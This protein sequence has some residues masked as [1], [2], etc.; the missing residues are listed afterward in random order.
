MTRR[1]GTR[2]HRP[3][4]EGLE[5]RLTLNA[6]G[7]IDVGVLGVV[8]VRADDWWASDGW[9]RFDASYDSS[10]LDFF[11]TDPFGGGPIDPQDVIDLGVVGV[12]TVTPDDAPQDQSLPYE[13]LVQFATEQG[14]TVTSTT[15]GAHNTG[16]AHYEGRAIDVR[17]RDKTPE[18]VERFIRE[19]RDAGITVFDERAR[20]PG[21][22]VW[23][24]PQGL[25]IDFSGGQHFEEVVGIECADHA[26]RS[27]APL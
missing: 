4:V 9:D 26:F 1:N 24:G 16:S 2:R 10:T 8:E 21:Q 18:Q 7:A 17:T 22:R 23:G 11:G 13:G 12:V 14:F 19:A 15:G 25:R 27:G 5:P 3:V 20:P 6:P